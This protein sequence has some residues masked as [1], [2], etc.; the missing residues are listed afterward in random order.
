[1]DW[2]GVL[3]SESAEEEEMSMLAI[4][5]SACMGKRDVD[6]E[7]EPTPISDGKH[8]KQ[9]LPDEKAK[10]NWAIIPEDSL[11]RASIDQPVL[12]GTPSKESAPQ[13][14]GILPRVLV[15]TKLVRG[16]L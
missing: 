12:E 1:M 4:R 6:L 8:P 11:N 5:F 10:K 3:A 13:E 7:D 16:P 2:V 14:E 9:S 15:L